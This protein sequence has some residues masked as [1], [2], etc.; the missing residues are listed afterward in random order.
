VTLAARSDSTLG[1]KNAHA[2]GLISIGNLESVLK[3][4]GQLFI[5]VSEI[6]MT[7]GGLVRTGSVSAQLP[8]ICV[9]ALCAVLLA[10][11]GGG[12]GYVPPPASMGTTLSI[13]T[14]PANQTVNAGQTATFSV[15]ANG[16]AP[17]S[18]QWQKGGVAIP[19]ATSAAYTTPAVQA[20]DNGT[21]F[22]V[23]V[24]DTAGSVSSS[25]ATL[26]VTTTAAIPPTTLSC[27]GYPQTQTNSVRVCVIVQEFAQ[28]TPSLSVTTIAGNLI[29]HGQDNLQSFVVYARIVAQAADQGAATALAN[30]VVINTANASVFATPNQATSPTQSLQID[31]EV[32]TAQTTNLTLTATDGN[33]AVD[34]YN[35]ILNLTTDA[36][37]AD[38]SAVQGQETVNTNNGNIDVT[39]IGTSFTGAGI[40]AKVAHAGNVTV[41]RPVGFQAAFTAE[42]NIG[43]AAIDAQ[44]QTAP[45][46]SP[47]VAT[48]GTGA[49][50]LLET[51]T[52]NVSVTH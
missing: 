5:T 7:T 25:A 42:T 39:L 48:S 22:T 44:T 19:G 11:G 16:T 37:N 35:A 15:T 3:P 31:F 17:L 14:Q 23:T 4:A 43:I 32:F 38:L 52:G 18:Y 41:S 20:S 24:T 51:D 47:A 6:S 2:E 30:S 9:A 21:T 28:V 34:N 10:C 40:T 13:T 29:G 1:N 46:N 8:I 27:A 26:T 12:S 45:P 49:P 36:G 50:I 33:L